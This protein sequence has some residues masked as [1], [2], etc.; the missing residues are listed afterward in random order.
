[1]LEKVMYASKKK[2]KTYDQIVR[3][4]SVDVGRGQTPANVGVLVARGVRGVGALE[5]G[6]LWAD[7][8]LNGALEGLG[9]ANGDSFVV[10]LDTHGLWV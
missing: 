8:L 4:V 5:C 1:M 6:G 7:W 9:G 10:A 2:K 3:H